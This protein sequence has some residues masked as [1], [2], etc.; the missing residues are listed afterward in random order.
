MELE[1]ELLESSEL[2]LSHVM[3]TCSQSVPNLNTS[4][5]DNLQVNKD[6]VA[7]WANNKGM[8]LSWE[9]DLEL[10]T[11]GQRYYSLRAPRSG[12]LWT[13]PE[14]QLHSQ[15]Q[16]LEL[17]EPSPEKLP[18]LYPQL[19]Q[20]TLEGSGKSS[21]LKQQ[22]SKA[23]QQEN[24]GQQLGEQPSCTEHLVGKLL[25][26][27]EMSKQMQTEMIRQQRALQEQ[28]GELKEK[29]NKMQLQL[30]EMQNE[31][32]RLQ[33]P[34]KLEGQDSKPK[35]QQQLQLIVPR[36]QCKEL[37]S[38]ASG[39]P[40]PDPEVLHEL[41]K[42]VHDTQKEFIEQLAEQQKIN[43]QLLAKLSKYKCT[44]L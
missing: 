4:D 22:P 29:Q 40:V 42:Q 13:V 18:M 25:Q 36:E 43:Q 44:I 38:P 6:H 17:A 34:K 15:V 27:Q 41:M 20:H 14:N 12:Q 3:M 16:Q 26:E 35:Q 32:E 11:K 23:L 9:E 2:C 30:K 5:K 33:Q 1:T 8:C 21:N 28:Q 24:T 10:H 39:M 31:V 37:R 7:Y 19:Q